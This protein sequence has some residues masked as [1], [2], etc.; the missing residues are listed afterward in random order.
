MRLDISVERPF[1]DV[2]ER[3]GD[4]AAGHDGVEQ[5]S[6]SGGSDCSQSVCNW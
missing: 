5:G 1:D 4:I 2:G 3:L 6:E